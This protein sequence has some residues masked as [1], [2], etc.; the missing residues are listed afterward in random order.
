MLQRSAALLLLV[1]LVGCVWGSAPA[2]AQNIPESVQRELERQGLTPEEARERARQLGI[3]LSNPDQA[4]RRARELGIP[5]AR[6]QALLQAVRAGREGPA[7][8]GVNTPS[9]GR[10][11]PT[12]SGAATISPDTIRMDRLP[13]AVQVEVPLRNEEADLIQRVEPFFLTTSGDTARVEDVQ[14]ISGSVIDGV[15]GGSYTVPDDTSA[16]TWPLFVRVGAADT[17]TVLRT[18]QRLVIAS[19]QIDRERERDRRDQRV[20]LDYFGYNTFDEVPASFRPSPVGP[21]DDGYIVGPNDE[22]RL[23]LWGGTDLQRD[24]QVDREGRVYIPEVGQFTVSGK[25]VDELRQ[26]MRSWLSQDF[27]GLTSDPPTVYMDLTVTRVRP[28]QV[29]VLGEVAQ[30]GGY[31]ISSY[32]TVFNA[33]YSVGGPLERGSLRNIKVVRDGEVVATV[34]LYNY[35]LRG[36]DPNPVQLQSN[37]YIFIP[38]RGKTVGIQ[39]AVKRP[40]YYEMKEGETFTDLLEYAGGLNPQAYT[41]R[42]QIERIVPFEERARSAVARRVLDFNLNAARAGRQPVSLAD[43][44]RVRVLSIM[45]AEE[46]AVAAQVEA[47]SVG[48]A[49]FQPGRYELSDSLRTVRDLIQRADGLTGDAYQQRA[50]L[51]RLNENL[52]EAVRSLD[53]K[54]VMADEP[55]A[56]VV[57]RPGDSLHVAS[58]RDLESERTVRITGQVRQ[59]GYYSYRDEMTVGDLLFMGGGLADDQYLKNVFMGRA[60]LYRE[61]PDGRS[62]R[63][64]PFHLGDA[65]DGEGFADEPLRPGDEIRI[66][67]LDV[68]VIRD[69]FVEISGAVKEPGQYTYREN[70]TLK[71][72][73]LQAE[74]FQEG[75]SLQA[76]EVTRLP[77]G[78]NNGQRAITVDVPLTRDPHDTRVSFS[79]TDTTRALEAASTFQLQH[80]DRVYV[81]TNPDFQPQ[82]TVTVRGEVR[83][84]GDYTLLQDN[85]TLFSIVQRAG[86]VRSTAYP[87]GGRLLRGNEQVIVEMGRAIQGDRDSDVILQAGDEIVIPPQPNTVAVRGNV[88]NEGLIKFQPGRRVEYYLDRAGGAMDDSEN[89]FLTQ[90]SGA[91]FKVKTGWFRMTP[92]VD[93]GAIIRVTQEPPKPERQQVDIGQTIRDV[94]G[95]LSSALTII[96]LATRAFN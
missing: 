17:S 28:V 45:E 67:P 34:D 90:A 41:K 81:R 88:A 47:A 3:D 2:H 16:G 51:F 77:E 26:E 61:S 1:I 30:P 13:Q 31:T 50:Q 53:V 96:V 21:V 59:P 22:L 42:F 58:V 83:F 73:I 15:W 12:L 49:V 32:S 37:D 46:P 24:L 71:D 29:F 94:T 56:N 65:L 66:Y 6:I 55:T 76:V 38:P 44:D 78:E 11:L 19:G 9:A 52:K 80:R 84:P 93:D 23:T 74:G 39:G 69:K 25:R 62:E 43:G 54:A 8:A 27:A 70:L 63:V 18:N 82:E 35:L 68:E 85:E 5:E 86:G 79:L 92:E 10:T 95:I 87:K 48:G 64:I 60:D 57:L 33:L 14:R 4:I 20:Q 7:L 36:S 89:I 40:A 75:A 72:L 91:T